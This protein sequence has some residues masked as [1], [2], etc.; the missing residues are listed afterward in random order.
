MGNQNS[1][2]SEGGSKES[3]SHHHRERQLLEKSASCGLIRNDGDKSNSSDKLSLSSRGS[4]PKLEIRCIDTSIAE[5]S[6]TEIQSQSQL[7]LEGDLKPSISKESLK[8]N[9][10]HHYNIHSPSVLLNFKAGDKNSSNKFKHPQC[11]SSQGQ[12]NATTNSNSS[13]FA[14]RSSSTLEFI[15]SSKSPLSNLIKGKFCKGSCDRLDVS[16]KGSEVSVLSPTGALGRI[17]KSGSDVLLASQ[18][19]N[20]N[21]DKFAKVIFNLLI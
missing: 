6:Q 4:E 13:L 16:G 19:M 7:S 8:V 11:T 18:K 5:K 21:L 2:F 20:C 12:Q 17:V 1:S 10:R 14:R 9:N 15:S 3:K